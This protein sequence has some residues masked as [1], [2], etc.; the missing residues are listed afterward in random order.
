[1]ATKKTA[2]RYSE[3]ERAEILDFIEKFNQENGRGGQTAAIKKFKVT[4][5][6]IGNWNKRN[7]KKGK[8]AVKAVK[9]KFRNP[10]K[11]IDRLHEVTKEIDKAEASLKKLTAEAKELRKEIRVAID[12]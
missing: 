11:L 4:A 7:G 10:A 1:M 6:T 2:K 12:S 9:K 8:S 5:L 3:P